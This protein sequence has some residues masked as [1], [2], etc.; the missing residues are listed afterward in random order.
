M[1]SV[2]WKAGAHLSEKCLAMVT[3]CGNVAS[4]FCVCVLYNM[5]G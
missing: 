3:W 1:Y 4:A 2:K 5:V